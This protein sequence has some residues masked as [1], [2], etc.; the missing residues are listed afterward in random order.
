[1]D[2]MNLEPRSRP[3][4]SGESEERVKAE[5]ALL[6]S[7]EE[8]ME[9]ATADQNGVPMAHAMHFASD[10]LVVYTSSLPR[11]RKLANI[12]EN[13]IVGY[14]VYVVSGYENRADARTLQV[15]GKASIVDDAPTRERVHEMMAQKFPWTP[16]GT[17]VHNVLIRIDPIEVL[18]SDF[19]PGGLPRQVV[20]FETL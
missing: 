17:L 16:K 6:L 4:T 18:W 5:M 20:Q 8:V 3:V 11:T 12:V 1:M 7:S 2:G 19:S 10:G 15:K 13:P 14:T 9:L